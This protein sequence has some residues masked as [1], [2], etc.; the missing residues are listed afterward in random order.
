MAIFS[1]HSL[2]QLQLRKIRIDRCQQRDILC[3]DAEYLR[4]CPSRYI[5][6]FFHKVTA[7]RKNNF[8][9]KPVQPQFHQI[10]KKGVLQVSV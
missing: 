5:K 2:Y 3:A 7:A 10:L 9:R 6:V 8:I 1:D 4:R